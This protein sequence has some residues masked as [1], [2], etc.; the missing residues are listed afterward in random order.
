LGAT[1]IDFGTAVRHQPDGELRKSF[2]RYLLQCI[3]EEG[4]LE[5]AEARL[6][7]RISRYDNGE[8]LVELAETLGVDV[9]RSSVID[10]G[11]AFGGDVLPFAAAGADTCATD[12]IDHH[13][14]ELQQ[15]ADDHGLRMRVL[16]ADAVRLPV[17]DGIFDMALVLDVLEHVAD[18]EAFAEEL[19]RVLRPGGLALITTP[20]RWKCL[21]RDPHFHAP[22][23][24]ALPQRLQRPV[25]VRLLRKSYPY[26]IYRIYPNVSQVARHFGPAGLTVCPATPWSRKMALLERFLPPYLS[27]PLRCRLW[28]I[29]IV[30]KA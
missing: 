2:S 29:L 1:R 19:A 24:H 9:S 28:E 21:G 22:L 11:C 7:W 26:P 18:A 20:A 8:R 25:A 3:C 10:I 17:R 5:R 6:Q 15:F 12:L 16:T 14:A 23:L 30:R 4:S 27:D 13:F